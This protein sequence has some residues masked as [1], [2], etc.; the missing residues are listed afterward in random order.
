MD[1]TIISMIVEI[2]LSIPKENINFVLKNIWASYL[3]GNPLIHC[4]V[5]VHGKI[6]CET[7]IKKLGPPVIVNFCN[8]HSQK[9]ID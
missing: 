8:L 1:F 2:L 4:P 7:L 6:L 9:N 3:S 5:H